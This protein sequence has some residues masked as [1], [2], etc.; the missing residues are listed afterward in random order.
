MDLNI[1]ENQVETKIKDFGV[2][3]VALIVFVAILLISFAFV[4]SPMRLASKEYGLSWNNQP[5]AGNIGGNSTGA[6]VLGAT[7]YNPNI[8]KEFSNIKVTL[9]A[10]NSST[11]LAEYA[12]Q[13]RTI[14]DSEN[15]AGLIFAKQTPDLLEKQ[16]KLLVDLG[17]LVVPSVFEDY[18]RL[19]LAE[20]NLEFSQKQGA[21]F[22]GVSESD[23]DAVLS[24]VR[25]QLSNIKQGFYNSVQLFLP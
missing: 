5:L 22:E 25:N 9:S 18:H 10:N 2:K 20:Y 1:L 3:N 15:A 24:A 13:V 16:D 8:A 19:L 17:N 11:A 23:I 7:E 12:N 21:T 14:I 6:Q 4:Q